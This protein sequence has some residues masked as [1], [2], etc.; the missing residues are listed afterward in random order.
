M[1][2]VPIAAFKDN[3]ARY[4]AQAHAGEEIVV[5]RHGK[6]MARL[7]AP[8]EGVSEEQRALADELIAFRRQRL[9]TSGPISGDDIDLWIAE[10]RAE[11]DDE[12]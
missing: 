11:W 6:P 1:P 8:F 7:V 10:G 2:Q 3:V 5:T 4:V 12:L 9:A